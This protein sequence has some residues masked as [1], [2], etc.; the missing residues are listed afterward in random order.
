MSRSAVAIQPGK[1]D[2]SPTG[3]AVSA[4]MA[5]LNARGML[6]E[7]ETLTLVLSVH[8]EKPVS[9]FVFGLGLFA[10]DGT[11]VYG[12]NT[13]IEDYTPRRLHGDAEVRLSLEDLRLVEGTYLV[14]LAAHK[15]DGTPYD[16]LRGLHSFRVKSRVKDVG[17]YRPRHHWSWS[18]GAELDPPAARA[19][20][21][22]EP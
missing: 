6:K 7:G 12:T 18:G 16:Y 17:L 5:I 19:D 1:I 11:S 10:A 4:R 3:T 9:D 13:D 2:R 21:V 22:G 14:D 8:A 15:K 20:R